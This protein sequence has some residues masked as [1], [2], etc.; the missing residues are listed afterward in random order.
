[1]FLKIYAVRRIIKFTPKVSRIFSGA[2]NM[3][4]LNKGSVDAG[5]IDHTGC[6]SNSAPADLR[7]MTNMVSKPKCDTGRRCLIYYSN[8]V[9]LVDPI[10][11]NDTLT[12]C[13]WEFQENCSI[14]LALS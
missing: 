5:G 7:I 10:S 14:F 1:M 4:R 12:K 9:I 13:T 3:N 2:L 11:R 8:S 6:H